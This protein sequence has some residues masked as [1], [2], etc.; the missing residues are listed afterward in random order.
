ML[1]SPGGA[2]PR[3][4]RQSRRGVG[5]QHNQSPMPRQGPIARGARSTRPRPAPTPCS[6]HGKAPSQACGGLPARRASGSCRCAHVTLAS[7]RARAEGAVQ[8][9]QR[10][11]L[12]LGRPVHV[13][14]AAHVRG[15][16]GA[17]CVRVGHMWHVLLVCVYACAHGNLGWS[18]CGAVWKAPACTCAVLYFAMS[19]HWP[20]APL[21]PGVR[22]DI[23]RASPPAARRAPGPG[24]LARSSARRPAVKDV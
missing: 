21:A 12:C 22:A 23:Q 13:R 5:R 24:P 16:A 6:L 2:C 3:W 10:N 15:R 11:G 7:P 19:S 14:P 18:V 1:P 17:D 9:A 20:V 4:G 8:A